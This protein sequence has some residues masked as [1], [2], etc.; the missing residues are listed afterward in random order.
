MVNSCGWLE[1]AMTFEDENVKI[2]AANMAILLFTLKTRV[3]SR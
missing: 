2:I 3:N 1:S